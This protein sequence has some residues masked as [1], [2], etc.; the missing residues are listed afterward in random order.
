MGRGALLDGIDGIDG[1]GFKEWQASKEEKKKKKRSSSS[2]SL[3][4]RSY[5]KG[6]AADRSCQAAFL[7][8]EDGIPQFQD[9]ILGAH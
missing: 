7:E 2:R 6:S 4:R 5:A 1:M 3:A 9:G 8:G